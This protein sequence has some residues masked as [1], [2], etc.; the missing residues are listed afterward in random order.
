MSRLGPVGANAGNGDV[1][2][3]RIG[4]AGLDPVQSGN[5]AQQV[6]RVAHGAAA[7]GEGARVEQ[8]IVGRVVAHD[9]PTQDGDVARGRH[10]AGVWQSVRIVE[11]GM[12]H[13]ELLRLAV[14]HRGEVGLVAADL[15]GDG[16]RH[17]VGRVD[18]QAAQRVLDRDRLAGVHAQIGAG[19]GRGVR[20]HGDEV[21]RLEAAGR[22]LFE[23]QVE[24]HQ[25]RDRGGET[26]GVGALLEEDLARLLVHHDPGEFRAALGGIQVGGR[27][28]LRRGDECGTCNDRNGCESRRQDA[29]AASVHV[30]MCL[31]NERGQRFGPVT[32]PA[33]AGFRALWT[34]RGAELGATVSPSACSARQD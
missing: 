25:L 11:E 19:L 4:E 1:V 23:R 2:S 5:H 32:T 7:V 21:G 30:A 27:P 22:H 16:H 29:L 13:P 33:R 3:G 31:G 6:V 34:R 28:G 9:R 20:R 14:H 15:L 26:L 18:G 10:L 17:V 24:G 8:L 12:L